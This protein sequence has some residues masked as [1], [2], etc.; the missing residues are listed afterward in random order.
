MAV[1]TQEK[2]FLY[3]RLALEKY[4]RQKR[5]SRFFVFFLFVCLF[6]CQGE[7]GITLGLA[8]R[9]GLFFF[10]RKNKGE[11]PSANE[12]LLSVVALAAALEKRKKV[13]AAAAW[14]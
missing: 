9:G 3:Y 12:R 13:S 7:R 14:R 6:S 2:V 8:G 5:L 10:K 1:E 11:N 4:F